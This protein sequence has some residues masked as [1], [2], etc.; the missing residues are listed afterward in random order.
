LS[1][2]RHDCGVPALPLTDPPDEDA[3]AATADR[4]RFQYCCAAARLLAAIAAGVE[5]EVIC[6]WHEDFLVISSDGN[7][8]AVSVKHRDD[9]SPAWTIATLGGQAGNLRRLLDTFQRANGQIHCCFETNRASNAD[10]NSADT[11]KRG[12]ARDD[13][14]QRLGATREELDEFLKRLTISRVPDRADIINTYADRYAAPALDR[15]GISGLEPSR[16]VRIAYELITEASTERLSTAAAVTVLAAAPADRR[17]V[18]Q[19][20][21]LKARCV[22]DDDVAAALQEAARELV[23]RL[24]TLEGEAPEETSMSKKLRAGGLGESVVDTAKR[25]R[26][27]WF[28]HRAQYRDIPYRQ[29]ELDSLQE[30]VQDQA[31]LAESFALDTG[32]LPYGRAM[33]SDLLARLHDAATVPDGTRPEDRHPTLLTGAAYQ[34]TD[35]CT[36]WFSPSEE[37]PGL[38]A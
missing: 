23:P 32:A 5:C 16:A 35:D 4:Y 2:L 37:V 36:V 3:G 22:N 29:E 21:V 15:L 24:P 33:H 26:T 8:E 14:A 28:A 27:G 12:A 7:V 30:W 17:T 13:L 19:A 20:E 1:K 38:D 11:T 6:E 31:N 18:I 10:L 25:R 34:L 9:G